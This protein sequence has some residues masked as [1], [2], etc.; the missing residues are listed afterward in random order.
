MHLTSHSHPF[1]VTL[2]QEW[3]HV[4]ILMMSHSHPC[5]SMS[6]SQHSFYHSGHSHPYTPTKSCTIATLAL[7]L[8]RRQR[9]CKGAGQEGNPRITFYVP[10]NVGECDGMNL[11]TPQVN[12]HFR[13]WNPNGFPYFYKTIVGVKTHWI[14]EFL[15]KVLERTCLK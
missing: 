15:G 13:N 4:P 11:H 14:Q 8:W 6:L 7:G 10:G 3:H 1:D 9:A 12:S 5:V 2:L